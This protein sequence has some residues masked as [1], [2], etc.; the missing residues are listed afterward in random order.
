MCVFIS[1]L[2][3]G[4]SS[5]LRERQDYNKKVDIQK[6]ILISAGI[7]V[8]DVNN[9][10]K[11]YNNRVMP[12]HLS[13]NGKIIKNIDKKQD[14]LEIFRVCEDND[15]AKTK[16]Y[17]YPIKGKGLWSSLYGYLSV[18]KTGDTIIGITFYKHGETPGLGAEIEQTWFKENFRGKKLYKD[19][20]Q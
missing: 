16:A 19:K 13:R 12:I 9:V 15:K 5:V 7:N 18:N 8:V 2:L 6:N 20:N 3:A 17:V 11:M 1:V 4:T 10:E 14:C